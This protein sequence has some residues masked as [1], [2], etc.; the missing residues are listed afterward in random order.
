[1]TVE[2]TFT[3][4]PRESQYYIADNNRASITVCGTYFWP[5]YFEEYEGSFEGQYKMDQIMFSHYHV[6]DSKVDYTKWGNIAL[7][8][9]IG[10]N[11][12]LT[13]LGADKD[14]SLVFGFQAW[15]ESRILIFSRN[16][17]LGEAKLLPE[18]NQFMIEVECLDPMEIFFIHVNNEDIR[19]GGN[20]FFKGITG[21]VV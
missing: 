8:P 2:A 20:W 15:S 19:H 3:L 5:H 9:H 7:V 17:Q 11:Y 14:L 4:T 13:D 18:D 6:A 12:D 16:E 1:M 21:F 10:F